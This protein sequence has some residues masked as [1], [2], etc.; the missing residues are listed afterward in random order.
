MLRLPD[1][2]MNFKIDE[3][4][5]FMKARNGGWD[6]LS[7][8]MEDLLTM[9]ED[10]STIQVNQL[11]KPYQEMT[12]ILARVLGQEST[13]TV[14][15]LSLYILYFFIQE[16]AIFDWSK[17]ISSEISFQLSNFRRDK[18]LYMSSYLIF[19]IIYCHVFKVLYL[20]M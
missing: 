7:Q 5:D 15:C 1:P 16:K 3:S 18:K 11:R 6:L 19:S 8:Y 12:W 13:I 17:I 4:K 14:P 9:S 2:T 20:T 10:I